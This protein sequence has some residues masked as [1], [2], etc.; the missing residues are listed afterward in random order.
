[1]TE[2]PRGGLQNRCRWSSQERLA[3]RW[4]ER[5]CE[6]RL[7]FTPRREPDPVPRTA[8]PGSPPHAPP[9][10][11]AE[12]AAPGLPEWEAS[13]VGWLLDVCPPEYRGYPGLRRHPLVLARFAV[14]HVEASQA[15]VDRGLSEA[16]GVLRDVA[17][18]REIAAA[19][20]TWQREAARL[21]GVR[22]AVGLVEEALRG[23][24]FVARM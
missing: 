7:V 24:R 17:T 22:R 6:D 20:E 18:E 12:V 5:V 13:A 2:N 4:F 3:R 19:L 16:R 9:G 21:I 15:A 1:M 11:P 8:P 23:R 10:W 14:L